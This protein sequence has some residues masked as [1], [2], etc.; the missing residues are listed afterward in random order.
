MRI[1]QLISNDADAASQRYGLLVEG[2]RSIYSAA[3]DQSHFGS[4]KQLRSIVAQAY[5]L[6]HT[7]LD[8][9]TARIEEVSNAVA[10]EAQGVTLQQLS[11]K[12]VLE[13]ADAVS[14]HVNANNEYLLR[15]I[16]VQIERDIAF[17]QKS[18]RST[19][20][21]VAIAARANRIPLRTALM[22]YRIGNASELAFFFHDRRNQRWPSRKFIRSVWR[23]H[24][25]ATYNEAVLLTLSD[26]G[27]DVAQI[28]HS[29]PK[30]DN[31][32][33]IISVASNSTLP[34]YA[35]I[36]DVIFHPNSEAVLTRVA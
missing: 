13:L 12:H 21:H 25:L 11:N 6:A 7:Y 18:V 3:L 23:Q 32:G 29:D 33:M 2:W 27:V 5:R 24:L 17:L 15:E 34:T 9:E 14:E 30:S 16:S 20:L 22:Q 28:D 10:L 31:H 26:H 4:E 8:D 35:E 19:Y 36:K 1:T